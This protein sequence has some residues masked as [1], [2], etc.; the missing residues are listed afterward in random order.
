MIT[1]HTGGSA[2][3]VLSSLAIVLIL[4]VG[5]GLS[6]GWVSFSD[7]PGKST[8]E[9]DKVKLKEDTDKAAAA[10]KEMINDSAKSLEDA[11][12]SVQ[13]ATQDALSER[14]DD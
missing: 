12:D 6:M 14:T 5:I 13:D 4:F 3:A 10:T 8:I 9:I 1:K 7:T 11:T 2:A